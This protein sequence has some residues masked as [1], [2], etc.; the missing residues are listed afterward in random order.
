MKID[1]DMRSVVGYNVYSTSETPEATPPQDKRRRSAGP[2]PNLKRLPTESLAHPTPTKEAGARVLR[3]LLLEPLSPSL[4]RREGKEKSPRG[5]LRAKSL[6]KSLQR[7]KT[8]GLSQKWR[9][10]GRK[11]GKRKRRREK[12]KRK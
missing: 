3:L 10:R 6:H 1:F 7:K 2:G 5:R 11:K 8:Q 9:N 12:K 4:S